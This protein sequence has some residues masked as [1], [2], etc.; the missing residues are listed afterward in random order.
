[1]LE[2][3]VQESCE[4]SFDGRDIAGSAQVKIDRAAQVSRH[5]GFAFADDQTPFRTFR[6]HEITRFEYYVVARRSTSIHSVQWIIL[7]EQKYAGGTE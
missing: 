6:V 5:F 1:M 2:I 4:S 3:F 7:C